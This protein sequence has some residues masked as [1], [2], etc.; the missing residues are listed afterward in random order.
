MRHNYPSYSI[1]FSRVVEQINTVTWR[2]S[3]EQQVVEANY[4][5]MPPSSPLMKELA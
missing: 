5:Q 3:S 1:L 4:V 2:E